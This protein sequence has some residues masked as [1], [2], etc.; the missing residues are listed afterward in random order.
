MYG[1]LS[2]PSSAHAFSKCIL[3][4]FPVAGAVPGTGDINVSTEVLPSWHSCLPCGKRNNKNFGF[5]LLTL[6]DIISVLIFDN[7]NTHRD[8]PP[9]IVLSDSCFRD[10]VLD[11]AMNLPL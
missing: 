11:L 3:S 7:F 9:D 8:D 2:S 5:C 4:V 10:L 1:V 6:F